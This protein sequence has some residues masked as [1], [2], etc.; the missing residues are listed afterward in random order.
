[1][2]RR[3]GQ[4]SEARFAA[5]VEALTGVIGRADRA[6]P[7]RAYGT[8]LLLPAVTARKAQGRPV[9]QTEYCRMAAKQKTL[10]DLFLQTLK[11]IYYAERKI[12]KSLP[13]M[14][15]VAE[16]AELKQAFETHREETQGQIERLEQVFDKLGKRASG[17]DLRSDQR[18]PGGGRERDGGVR[19]KPGAGSRCAG[20]G[21]GG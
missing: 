11:D 9:Q 8:G 16:S 3:S 14:A 13:R 19:R 17:R 4:S 15:K 6:A 21:S 1:M 18:H 10:E 5:Y 20:R 12:L 7:L 2:A